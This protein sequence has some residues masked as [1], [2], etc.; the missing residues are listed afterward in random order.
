MT[1]SHRPQL[2]A[3]NGGKNTPSNIEHS[4]LLPSHTKVKYRNK[5]RDYL[6]DR[7]FS[8]KVQDS[9]LIE[10]ENSVEVT[11]G[12][13]NGDESIKSEENGVEEDEEDEEDASE[14]EREFLQQELDKIREAKAKTKPVE[15]SQVTQKESTKKTKKSW[16]QNTTFHGKK[17]SS[18][19]EGKY[20]NNL[21]Q[22]SYH[23][24]FMNKFIK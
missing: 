23:Q 19:Q 7:E 17:Q 5:Q 11:N 3:R 8:A 18:S 20:I 2:E 1:T 6:Q 16:R 22:S 9:V 24:Q 15:F 14:D 21:S 13:E 4:R 12:D 10:D